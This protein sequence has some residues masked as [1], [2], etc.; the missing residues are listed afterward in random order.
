MTLYVG[1]ACDECGDTR[2]Q[3]FLDKAKPGFVA[4]AE[5]VTACKTLA[6][7]SGWVR[8]GKNWLC[9]GCHAELEKEI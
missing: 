5:A 1:L 7:N 2:A 6:M 3:Q 8:R 9:S 4:H